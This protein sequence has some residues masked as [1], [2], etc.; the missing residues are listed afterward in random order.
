MQ[1]GRKHLVEQLIENSV[2]FEYKLYANSL[3]FDRTFYLFYQAISA[4]MCALKCVKCAQVASSADLPSLS[5][6]QDQDS[7]GYQSMIKKSGSIDAI[8]SAL[9][10]KLP[11]TWNILKFVQIVIL[12]LQCQWLNHL[13]ALIFTVIWFRS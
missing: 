8:N 10:D 12:Y 6:E 3:A 1:I 4:D 11:V 9:P 2:E 5:S 13:S 7:Q